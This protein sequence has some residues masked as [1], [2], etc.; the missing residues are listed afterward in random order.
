MSKKNH[1]LNNLRLDEQSD[2][3]LSEISES[4]DLSKSA[5][6]RLLLNRSLKE[7]KSAITL[8]GG[9]DKIVFQIKPT[10]L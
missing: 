8:S 5:L 10:E 4:L 3:L 1:I 2:K 9:L 6:A 7:L